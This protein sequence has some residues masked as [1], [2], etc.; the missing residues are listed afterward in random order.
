[1]LAAADSEL[2]CPPEIRTRILFLSDGE[3]SFKREKLS[4]LMENLGSL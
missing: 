1:M 4:L 3:S 2:R